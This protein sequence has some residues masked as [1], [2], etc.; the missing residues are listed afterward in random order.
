[1][2]LWVVFA[3]LT[4]VAVALVLG[5]LMR[6]R[7]GAAERR[8]D[9]D[10]EVY[11]D[12]LAEIER[13]LKRGLLTA[14]QAEAAKT[15][16]QRRMLAAAGKDKPEPAPP[17]AGGRRHRL[18]AATLA[19]L[20]PAGALGL[21]FHLGSPGLPSRPYAERQ[22]ERERAAEM[23]DILAVVGRLAQRLERT[24]GDLRGWLLLGRSYVVLER[25]RDGAEAYARAVELSGGRPDVTSAYAEALVMAEGGLV[26]PKAKEAFAATLDKDPGN[27]RA[28]FYLGL[29]LAQEGEPREALR[30]WAALAG[31]APE[32]A[33][34][35]PTLREHMQTL[36]ERNGI[37]LATLEPLR[38][39]PAAAGEDAAKGVRPN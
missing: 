39:P 14:D 4:A 31:D 10:L 37:D 11:R 28:R 3:A 7:R 26:T 29:A 21:Y 13:D 20:I 19:L 5:P 23:Q 6:Q 27:S 25:Y 24:P 32:D 8:A 16:I 22:A 33:P 9:Y 38:A 36:A 1:M 2:I 35:L 30:H 15:E 12:Q 18:A 17:P 34:W